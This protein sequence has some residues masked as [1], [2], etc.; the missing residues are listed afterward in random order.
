MRIEMPPNNEF[1]RTERLSRVAQ[2]IVSYGF[3]D[4]ISSINDHKGTLIIEWMHDKPHFAFVKLLQQFWEKENE[5]TIEVL[6]KSKP[7]QNDL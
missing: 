6:Y 1:Y 2:S 4:E 5:Y 7:I 3:Q